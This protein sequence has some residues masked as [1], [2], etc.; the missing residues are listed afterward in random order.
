MTQGQESINPFFIQLVLSLQSAAWYQ[1]GK[2]ASP[3]TGKIDRDLTQAENAID[4]LVMLQEKT[5]GNLS[6]D[7]K[8]ILDNT[9]YTLQMNYLDEVER[10]KH[11]ATAE[12]GPADAKNRPDET[13]A[14]S[15]SPEK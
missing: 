14:T 4:L 10:E 13:D 11:A 3:I 2:V 1:M 5:K 15:S 12:D 9:I 6:D 7:E 8:K